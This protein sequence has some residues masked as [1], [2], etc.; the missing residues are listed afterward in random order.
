MP[1]P[2][3]LPPAAALA[4]TDSSLGAFQLTVE[5]HREELVQLS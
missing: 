1:T 2:D 3:I 4:A 5:T